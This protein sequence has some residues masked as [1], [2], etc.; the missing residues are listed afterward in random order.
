MSVVDS[1][2]KLQQL[3]EHTDSRLHWLKPSVDELQ[4]LVENYTVSLH[5]IKEGRPQSMEQRNGE[6]SKDR[7]EQQ[8]GGSNVDDGKEESISE[9]KLR[10]MLDIEERMDMLQHSEDYQELWKEISTGVVKWWLL[11]QSHWLPRERRVPAQTDLI[12]RLQMAWESKDSVW[13][14]G[15]D[16][17]NDEQAWVQHVI[18]EIMQQIYPT[19]NRT[20][21]HPQTL[22]NKEQLLATFRERLKQWKY[23]TDNL[24]RR[25]RDLEDMLESRSQ[26]QQVKTLVSGTIMRWNVYNEIAY[27][28]YTVYL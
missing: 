14:L 23:H 13:L 11:M 21:Q 2:A 16:Q 20:E 15:F 22:S 19:D 9:G 24:K 3:V 10:I 5:R 25:L 1:K 12:Q 7:K 26:H 6:E 4:R 18:P 28:D 17:W 8:G 27:N